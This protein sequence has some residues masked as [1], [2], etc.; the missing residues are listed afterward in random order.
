MTQSDLFRVIVGAMILASVALTVFVS[1]WFLLFTTFIGAN[2]FQ[3]G[4][5]RICPMDN[6]LKKTDRPA[7]PSS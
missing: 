7:Y 6:M 4:F 1:N 2:M 5:T 3:S